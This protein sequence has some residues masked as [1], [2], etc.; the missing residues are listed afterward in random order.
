MVKLLT[1]FQLHQDICK[2]ER[3]LKIMILSVLK[4]T[5]RPVKFW[6]IKNYLSPPFK[7]CIYLFG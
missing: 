6:F 5:H 1:Y 7:V 4:K 2:Y 3:F